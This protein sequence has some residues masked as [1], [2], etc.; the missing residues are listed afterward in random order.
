MSD[1]GAAAPARAD[2]PA[3]DD[4]RRTAEIAEHERQLQEILAYCPAGLSVVDEDGRLIF[5]N[6]GLRN[7]LGYEADELHLFDTRRFWQD[8]DQRSKIIAALREPGGQLLNQEVVWKT[9]QGRPVHVLLS[10]VQV[11][12]QGGH[13]G[14]AGG[15]RI[16]WVYDI[17]ELKERE[18]QIAEEQRQFREILEC[19]PAGLCSSTRTAG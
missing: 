5:H 4:H 10:Y 8:V 9:K 6:D 18:A 12:Y 17:T 11:A 3:A 15:A 19:S 14:F 1:D 7:L 2:S 13:V 16:L